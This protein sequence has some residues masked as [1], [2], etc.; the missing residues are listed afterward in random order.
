MTDIARPMARYSVWTRR[1]CFEFL[2]GVIVLDPARGRVI[3]GYDDLPS[4]IADRIGRTGEVSIYAKDRPIIAQ[5]WYELDRNCA[6][7]EGAGGSMSDIFKLT[8]CFREMDH[9]PGHN[10]VRWNFFSA[11]AP[12]F[13]V[14]E[15]RAMMPDP[16]ILIEDE[17]EATAWLGLLQ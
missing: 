7:I 3:R 11:N 9:F 1:G 10:T 13:P 12:V 5:S 8:Q 17:A 14:F 16:G 2:S 4:G 15:I 6:I